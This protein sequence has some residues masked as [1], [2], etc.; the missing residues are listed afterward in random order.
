MNKKFILIVCLFLACIFVYS[1]NKVLAFP[2]TSDEIYISE[3]Q[4]Y[5]DFIEV[6]ALE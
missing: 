4:G 1:F 5:I 2:A 6:K 3:C